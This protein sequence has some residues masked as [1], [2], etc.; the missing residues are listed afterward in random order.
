MATII[1][2]TTGIDKIQDGTVVDADI[3]SLAA[4]KL[5]GDLPAIDGSAL[6]G[7]G[8]SA[9]TYSSMVATT[10]GTSVDITGIPSGVKT[11]KLMF[12][13]VRLNTT[14]NWQLQLGD[15]GGIETSGYVGAYGYHSEPGWNLASG[16]GIYN[17]TASETKQGFIEFVLLEESSNTWVAGGDVANNARGYTFWTAG[18]K[19]L[20]SEL[21]TVRLTTIAGTGG[22]NAGQIRVLYEE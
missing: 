1:N 19:S 18:K 2:G 8:G 17:D 12:N 13:G 10:S 5:T 3:A 4:S 22:F 6:T 14:G 20:S 11:I 16:F 21:T 9:G 7:V 15:S